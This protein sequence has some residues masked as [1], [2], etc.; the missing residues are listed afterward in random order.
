MRLDQFQFTHRLAELQRQP[1]F[2]LREFESVID[3]IRDCVA[4]VGRCAFVVD[5]ATQHI[6][7]SHLSTCTAS[8]GS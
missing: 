3:S 2:Q 6:V 8:L 4:E 1:V 5:M 7:L